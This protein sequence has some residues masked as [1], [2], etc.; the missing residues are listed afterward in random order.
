MMEVIEK[1][2]DMEK[3]AGLLKARGQTIGFVPTM[4]SLHDGHLSLIRRA[5]EKNDSVIL[6]IFVNPI[7]FDRKDDFQGYPRQLEKDLDVAS[8][9]GVD[10]VF[11]PGAEQIYPEGFSAYVDVDGGLTSGLCGTSRPGHFRG[12]ATVVARLF[13]IIR[14]DRAYFGRKDLQQAAVIKRVVKDLDMDV[15]VVTLPAVREA[16]G[17]VLSSRNRHL[18]DKQ[19]QTALSIHRALERAEELFTSGERDSTVLVREMRDV[20]TAAG[21]SKIDYI[22]IVEPETL[23]GLDEAYPGAVAAIAAWVGDTRLIDN[24]ALG[25]GPASQSPLHHK[26]ETV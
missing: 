10:I 25:V 26:V 2:K 18:T 6:S 5:R 13:D 14:P 4:G 8:G 20:L 19:R 12:V 16:D 3:R 21:V 22:S 23:E 17:L 1:T 11:T 15:D 9:E 7:Q 24:T